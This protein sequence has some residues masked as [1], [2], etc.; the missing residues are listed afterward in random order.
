MQLL[1]IIPVIIIIFFLLCLKS[2]DYEVFE[3]SK[4]NHNEQGVGKATL[5]L[6]SPSAFLK[7]GRM[8]L[9]STMGMTLTLTEQPPVSVPH[10][11]T[12]VTSHSFSQG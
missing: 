5:L 2:L 3:K 9:G 1:V 10:R 4:P 12:S 8:H 6:Y 7:W 11:K